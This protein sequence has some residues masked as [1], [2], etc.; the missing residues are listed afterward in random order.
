M[1]MNKIKQWFNFDNCFFIQIDDEYYTETEY[2]L[3]V[4]QHGEYSN[5]NDFIKLINWF[6]DRKIKFKLLLN[7]HH[8]KKAAKKD[9]KFVKELQNKYKLIPSDIE[10][11][12]EKL[13]RRK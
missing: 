1:E 3:F 8:D 12:H 11:Y 7:P 6:Y 13:N 5:I 10:V 9:Y 4:R 2:D